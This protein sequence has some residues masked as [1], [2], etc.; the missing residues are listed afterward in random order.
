MAPP[1]PHPPVHRDAGAALAAADALAA[2]LAAGAAERDRDGG[3][4]REALARLDASGLLAI[5][6]PAAYGGTGGGPALLAEVVRRIAV[7]DPAIA[8]VPQAH[9]LFVDLLAVVGTAAQRERLFADVVAGRRIGNALAERG[10]AHAQ[11]LKTR[12]RRS[13]GGAVTISGTKA[14]AT[15]ALTGAWIALSALDDAERLTLVFVGRDDP[16]VGADEVWHAMG[17]RATV[18]GAVTLDDVAVDPALVVDLAAV[19]EAPQLL[20]ARAQLVH[21]AIETG[22]ARAAVADAAAFLGEKAR[23]FFE[24]VRTG[25][26]E[27]ASDDPYALHRLG[28][29]GARA[30]AAEALLAR[31]AARL[32]ALGPVPAD[33]RSSAEGSLA[34][35]EVKAFAS[36]VAVEAGSELFAIGGTSATDRRLDLDRHWRN[37]R[38]HSV[39][40]PVDW[41]YHHLGGFLVDGRLPPNHAQ[42]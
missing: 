16:G 10:A 9:F 39:H 33:E 28:R 26:V 38:T 37:A 24:A 21:A 34:V 41:K 4:P 17:Q 15:G 25:W 31:A 12:V 6:V 36:E 7:A 18:S 22:I 14:Y 3:V 2:E 23:P 40:D 27:K 20:G 32:E 11:A 30:S 8:Q 35:A 1:V 29:I 5:T 42:L 13:A 19:F